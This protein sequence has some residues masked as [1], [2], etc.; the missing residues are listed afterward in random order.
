M[1]MEWTS[2]QNEGRSGI[3]WIAPNPHWQ[4]LC[5]YKVAFKRRETKLLRGVN[6]REISRKTWGGERL[7]RAQFIA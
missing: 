5:G 6:D 3:I 7:S 1:E 4:S 2:F